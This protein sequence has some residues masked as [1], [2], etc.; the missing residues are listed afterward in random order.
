MTKSPSDLRPILAA[1]KRHGLLLKQDP[2]L[3]SVVGIVTGEA[4][5][6]SWWNHPQNKKIFALLEA[7][8]DRED[9]LETKL[10]G[11]V[12]FVFESL[13]AAWLGVAI[14]GEGWQR[15]G[16]SVAAE[17]L[18]AEVERAGECEASGATVKELEARLLVRTSQRHTPSGHH[19]LVLE[20]WQR[21]AE[22]V[23]VTPLPIAAA[24]SA[25]ETATAALGAR[26]SLLPWQRA[27]RRQRKA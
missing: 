27:R 3:P 5:R 24:M 8:E 7:L 12:T 25:L 9:V 11:K 22:R 2:T 1:L 13:W 4:L 18:L 6:T 19:V 23:A 16:L 10:L 26:V 21:W 15:T 20:G 17:H 14:G